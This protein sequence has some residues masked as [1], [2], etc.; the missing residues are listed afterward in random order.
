MM[1]SAVA[2]RHLTIAATA[3]RLAL[4]PAELA[5]Q[6]ARRMLG[7]T[8][9]HSISSGTSSW[10]DSCNSPCQQNDILAPIS[11][12]SIEV[13]GAFSLRSLPQRGLD[14]VVRAVPFVIA[15]DNPTGVAIRFPFGWGLP[16]ATSRSNT[17]GLGIKPLGL[18]GWL[19]R[20]AWAVHAEAVGG[21][22]RFGR[23]MLASNAS[24]FNFVYELG[25]GISYDIPGNG[26]TLISYR[27]HHL[28]NGGLG[29]VNPGLNSHVIALSY[30]FW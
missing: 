26:R 9:A 13:E 18:R 21:F 11:I 5:G 2:L 4:P 25:V 19:R 1:F 7:V 17:T 30:V 16:S 28:S 24:R 10:P 6:D 22:L 3:L 20:N 23:P 27:R 14:Y 8:L 15:R 29:Q 12:S